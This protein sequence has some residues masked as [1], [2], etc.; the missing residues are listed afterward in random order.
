MLP[1][2]LLAE[3]STPAGEPITLA[4]EGVSL[5]VR[6]RNEVLMSS[7][8]H[9]SEE[10]MAEVGCAGLRER[11]GVRVLIGGL[12]L[13]YTVRAALDALGPDAEVVVREL[14]PALVEW[15]R[16]TLGELAGRP[17]DDPRVRVEIGDVGDALEPSRFDAILL[18]VD[19]GPEALTVP[20]NARLYGA[21]GL[22]RL[23]TS[24]RPGGALVV[25]SAF[26]SPRFAR[27][28]RAAG[29]NGEV[30]RVRARGKVA[31]GSR[32]LLY[33]GRAAR[34]RSVS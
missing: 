13:G 1:R 4:R 32:H 25:W 33:V 29:L 18:D 28:L 3:A 31:R 19:N 15:N 7:R 5:V 20:S 2:E 23:R 34:L 27:A 21:R 9:G 10:A 26:E 11:R 16:G 12:G 22:E 14:I 6:V 17:L 24:L 8:V 30:V